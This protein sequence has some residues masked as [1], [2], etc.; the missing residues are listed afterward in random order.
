MSNL[1]YLAAKKIPINMYINFIQDYKYGNCQY[2]NCIVRN[3]KVYVNHEKLKSFLYFAKLLRAVGPLY[4]NILICKSF[5]KFIPIEMLLYSQNTIT[6]P[7]VRIHL[8]FLPPKN[9]S[10]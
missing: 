2:T 5:I 7:R 4:N 6:T 3:L 9:N 8:I 1:Y 10:S